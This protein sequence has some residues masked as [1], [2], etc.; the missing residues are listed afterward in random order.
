ML[1][2]SCWPQKREDLYGGPIRTDLNLRFIRI[3][4]DTRVAAGCGCSPYAGWVSSLAAQ[5]SRNGFGQ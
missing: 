4:G 1:K 5:N 3:S 2:N